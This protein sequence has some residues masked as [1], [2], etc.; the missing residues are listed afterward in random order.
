MRR[1]SSGRS[2]SAFRAARRS[3]TR[4][5]RWGSSGRSSRS[6]TRP[7]A[8]STSTRCAWPVAGAEVIRV[9]AGEEIARLVVQDADPDAVAVNDFVVILEKGARATFNILNIGG[10][11]GRVSI[12]VTCHEGSHFELAGAIIGGG[13]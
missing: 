13:D 5:C 1:C 9:A 11:F 7:T 6:L 10:K 2:M 4:W 8:G 12:D 3:A